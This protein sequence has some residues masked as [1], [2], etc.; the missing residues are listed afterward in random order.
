V[1]EWKSD[2]KD[3]LVCRGIVGEQLQEKIGQREV[4][5][6]AGVIVGDSARIISRPSP[7]YFREVIKDLVDRS[8]A[9]KESSHPIQPHYIGTYGG[10]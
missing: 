8:R 5:W 6:H 7:L 3:V 9:M 4:L 1:I 2:R 10:P